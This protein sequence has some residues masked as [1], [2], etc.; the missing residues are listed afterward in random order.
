MIQ[1]NWGYPKF[2]TYEQVMQ[3]KCSLRVQDVSGVKLLICVEEWVLKLSSSFFKKIRKILRKRISGA[4][5]STFM[6]SWHRQLKN[7]RRLTFFVRKN[8][9]HF[10]LKKGRID[11]FMHRRFLI[12]CL[13]FRL[14]FVEQKK[15]A[16][17]FGF[18]NNLFSK[19]WNIERHG[20]V[21]VFCDNEIRTFSDNFCSI[22]I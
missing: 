13:F 18:K 19:C 3:L 8:D 5:T 4:K 17:Y 2:A 6:K 20:T 21:K 9:R 14:P 15:L 1:P 11:D 16:K 10:R 22:F 12:R 7:G